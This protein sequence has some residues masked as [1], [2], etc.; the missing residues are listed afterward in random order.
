LIKSCPVNGVHYSTLI[1]KI[2]LNSITGSNKQSSDSRFFLSSN[3]KYVIW[4]GATGE[5]I[6]VE[7]HGKPANGIFV[8]DLIQKKRTQISKKTTDVGVPYLD[9]TDQIY[10][11]S[12]DLKSKGNY[13]IFKQNIIDQDSNM[14]IAGSY[15]PSCR[16]IE[17]K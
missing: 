2:D 9:T 10:Y 6:D 3:G 4:N 5:T 14:I 7:G 17:L 13:D 1:S 12:R 11:A 8:Y 15:S 16:N